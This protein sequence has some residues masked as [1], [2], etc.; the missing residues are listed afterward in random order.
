MCIDRNLST[1]ILFDPGLTLPTYGPNQVGAFGERQRRNIEDS[2][3]SPVVTLLLAF[4]LP[5]T[6]HSTP[7][8]FSAVRV[9]HQ[10]Y[11]FL[12]NIDQMF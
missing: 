3:D 5:V 6:M 1:Y 9:E 8:R 2:H 4:L 10:N 7:A 12:L 11:G